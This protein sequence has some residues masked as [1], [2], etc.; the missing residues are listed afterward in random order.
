MTPHRHTVRDRFGILVVVTLLGVL[1]TVPAHAQG[2]TCSLAATALTFGNYVPFSSTPTDI[3]ATITVNCSATGSSTVPISGTLGLTSTSTSYSRQLTNGTYIVRYHTYTD[4][5]RTTFWGNG[6][7]LGVTQAVSG[8][9]GPSA[10]FQQIFT[11]Y[12]RIPALQSTAYVGS[13]ADL[14]TA[15]LNY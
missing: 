8:S 12:G 9:V 1:A 15:T 14:I 7:G 11:V 3:T 10:P 2:A 13:Y 6:T 5:A 4:F